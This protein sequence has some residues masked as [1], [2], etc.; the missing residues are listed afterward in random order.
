MV[1]VLCLISY[2]RNGANYILLICFTVIFN[3]VCNIPIDVGYSSGIAAQL[4]EA[5]SEAEDLDQLDTSWQVKQLISE[6]KGFLKQMIRIGGAKENL[7]IT[8]QIIG[9]ISY[10]WGDIIDNFTP[11]MQQG[12]KKDPSLVSKLRA[13]FLKVGS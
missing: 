1:N 8:L 3:F 13:T 10:A 7:L 5:L 2:I 11:H 12:V 9:D 4:I 6:A